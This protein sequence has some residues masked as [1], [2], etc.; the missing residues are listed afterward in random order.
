MRD[1]ANKVAAVTGAASGIGRSLSTALASR[2]CH[3]ALCD[4]DEAGLALTASEARTAGVRVTA[5]K[6]DVADRAAMHDWAARTVQEHGR[7]NLVFNNAGVAVSSSVEGIDYA[8]FEWII[9]INFWGVVHGTK[10]F[11]PYLKASGEGHVVNISSVFGLLAQP[12][13]SAY[14]ASKFAV[15]GFTEA[16]RQELE[17]QRHP[18]SATCVLPAG[19]KTNIVRSARYAANMRELSGQDEH[20]AKANFERLLATSADEAARGI[21]KAVEKNKRRVLIGRGARLFDIVQR[22]LPSAYQGLTVALLRRRKRA[23]AASGTAPQR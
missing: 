13:Q 1:F 21:L 19:I 8:D 14:N 10:A 17:L 6:V 22:L 18:V 11:L 9:G 16:L 15:R 4:I 12:S 5:A 23:A 2:G 3:L 7:V 20:T